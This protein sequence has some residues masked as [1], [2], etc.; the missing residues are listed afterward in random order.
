MS[1]EHRSGEAEV[2]IESLAYGGDGVGRLAG[3]AVF[4]PLS[5]PG[6]RLRVALRQ[7]RRS[8]VR[9]EMVDLLRAGTA[10][11]A[12]PCELFGHCGGC[13]WQHIAYGVQSASKREVLARALRA[14]HCESIAVIDAP[15]ELGYRRR[16]RAHWHAE[17]GRFTLGFHRLASRLLVDVPRCLL[18]EPALDSAWNALRAKRLAP[19]KGSGSLVMLAGA[20]GEVHLSLRLRED[21]L[22]ADLSDF[23]DA[24][25]VGLVAT[26]PRGAEL[27]MGQ[28]DIRLDDR[29]LRASAAAFTQAAAAQD[30]QLRAHVANALPAGSE[31]ILELHAG[32]GNLTAVTTRSA[33]E[34]VAVESNREA[35]RLLR[36]NVELFDGRG[37][38][39]RASRVEIVQDTA[40]RALRAGTLRGPYE[41]ILLDPPREGARELVEPLAELG[42]GLIVYVSC[43]PM[44]LARDL[45]LFCRRGYRVEQVVGID[46]MPQSYHLEV[47]ASLVRA[48]CG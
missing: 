21:T 8:Y 10:R 47:V 29:G 43:D 14:M 19:L 6:D 40:E 30:A 34:V 36:K 7:E 33:H 31:R 25:I 2:E 1:G 41:A 12:A 22:P 27:R 46:M 11:R 39:G 38:P 13:Q 4:V 37:E 3:K 23:L 35:V 5:A 16:V 15:E 45:G 32:I 44:T 42:A 24:N 28:L 20:D 26:D 9:A 48:T 17:G 18:A